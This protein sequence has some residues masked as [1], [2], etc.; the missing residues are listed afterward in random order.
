MSNAVAHTGIR[1]VA[2]GGGVFQN[3]KANLRVLESGAVDDL[4][5]FPGCGDE[6]MSVGAAYV[7]SFD[8]R[9]RAGAGP[10]A[11]P[12]STV[13]LG[14]GF[15]PADIDSVV[16]GRSLGGRYSVEL[17][18]D[19]DDR[20]ASLLAQGHI[21]ARFTGRMEWGP[22]ALG[23][24]SILADPRRPELVRKLNTAIKQR[25]FWMPF[26][27]TMLWDTHE[28]YLLNPHR[29]SSPH[30]MA[31]FRTTESGKRDFAAAIHPYDETARPQLLRQEDNPSYYRLIGRFDA[32]TGVP[33]LLNTSFNLH[34]EPIVCSPEDAVSTFERSDLR[35]LALGPFL[36]SK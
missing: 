29:A 4:Y 12:L 19:I 7:V 11:A 34:G 35:H 18:E 33:G 22:R 36:I 30:M 25:D 24:R 27:P 3:V 10:W 31:A 5:V 14:S 26:A 28:R 23:N 1:R 8:L 15:S 13:Y 6:S 16:R 21:V 9:Q 32:L 2:C 17:V 20:V